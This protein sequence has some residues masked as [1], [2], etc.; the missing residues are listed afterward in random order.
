MIDEQTILSF[1]TA[2]SLLFG[3]FSGL[4]G[5]R[6]TARRD[7]GKNASEMMMVIVKLEDI[8]V[9]VSEIK[10]DVSNV[11]GDIYDEQAYEDMLRAAQKC[12]KGKDSDDDFDSDEDSEEGAGYLNDKQFLE[13]V[14][15]AIRHG[16]I[17]TSLIQRKIS[18]GYGKAAK[19]I[20]IMEDLGVVSEPNGSK[21][22]D[23][24][25]TKNEWEEML[26]RRSLD[27]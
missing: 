5:M 13:A 19:F 1:V 10:A 7:A 15:L 12:S 2:C 9:G 17:S 14:E 25:V 23:I 26:A 11:K 8:S 18:V 22:R 3:V 16:K 4:L 20:D 27:D 6:R 21:P 24:L